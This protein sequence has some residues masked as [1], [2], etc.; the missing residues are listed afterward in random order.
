MHPRSILAIARKDA[1][2]ILLNKST[3]AILI[4]PILLAL[5]FLVV[6]RLVGGQAVN[7]LVYNPGQSRLVQ[8]ICSSFNPVK[9]TEVPS[10]D[11]VSSAFGPNGSTKDAAYDVGLIIPA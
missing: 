6:T 9:V 7:V 2:D 1:I 4:S 3:L 11:D 8:V 5:L 10:P